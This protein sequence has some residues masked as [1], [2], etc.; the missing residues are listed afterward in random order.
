MPSIRREQLGAIPI[1]LTMLSRDVIRP[2][3]F[4]TAGSG[5]ATVSAGSA[6]SAP[7]TCTYGPLASRL[8]KSENMVRAADGHDPV[9]RAQHGGPVDLVGHHGERAR[10]PRPCRS[11]M[12]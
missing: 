6:P 11:A 8:R 5:G 7:N 10:S 3:E 4:S 2:A 9:H 1:T 12:R